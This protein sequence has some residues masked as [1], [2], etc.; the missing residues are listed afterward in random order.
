MSS[1]NLATGQDIMPCD[2]QSDPGESGIEQKPTYDRE[3]QQADEPRHMRTDSQTMSCAHRLR[4][5][6]R[7][8]GSG[9]VSMLQQR[10]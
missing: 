9:P 3:E 10:D 1:I 6:L 5:D 7:E 8:A 2:A 4:N